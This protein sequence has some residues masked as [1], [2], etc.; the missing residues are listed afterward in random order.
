MLKKMGRGKSGLT[1]H[2][3]QEP[4][5]TVSPPEEGLV[6]SAPL[7]PGSQVAPVLLIKDSRNLVPFTLLIQG[8]EKFNPSQ[9]ASATF[10]IIS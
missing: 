2:V 10:N 3:S 9:T 8:P 1:T 4:R 5:Q 6:F 7:A